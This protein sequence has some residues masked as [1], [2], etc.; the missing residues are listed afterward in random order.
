[1]DWGV[2]T[3]H[4]APEKLARLEHGTTESKQSTQREPAIRKGYQP[5]LINFCPAQCSTNP[6]D[7]AELAEGL[8]L[9]SNGGIIVDLHLLD[10]GIIAIYVNEVC[11]N[12]EI[13]MADALEAIRQRLSET[14]AT[15]AKFQPN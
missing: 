12:H 10:W 1:M 6:D 5:E 9:E 14:C 11:Q 8:A 13:S 3:L 15:S 2:D 4:G 7:Y